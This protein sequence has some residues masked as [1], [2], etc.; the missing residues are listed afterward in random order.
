MAITSK[1]LKEDAQAISEICKRYENDAGAI[2]M[3][4]RV[5]EEKD[6]ENAIIAC[7]NPVRLAYMIGS[8]CVKIGR[9]LGSDM[10][11][12]AWFLAIVK[13]VCGEMGIET[14]LVSK[15]SFEKDEN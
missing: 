5:N 13:Q 14:E 2:C 7:G 3:L 1:Q 4:T 8:M 10:I 15:L 6:N 11:T 9:E 12:T